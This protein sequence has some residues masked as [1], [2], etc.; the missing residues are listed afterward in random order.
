MLF[1]SPSIIEM[2]MFFETFCGG[3][4]SVSALV[5]DKDSRSVCGRLLC[6]LGLKKPPTHGA[7]KQER[8]D[9][10]LF[11]RCSIADRE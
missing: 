2:R 11:N 7:A 5:E 1:G 4:D 10:T 9:P 8:G 3:S 6:C